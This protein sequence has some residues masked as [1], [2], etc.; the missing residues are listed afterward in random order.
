MNIDV[1]KTTGNVMELQFIEGGSG[2]T[3]NSGMQY[4][5]GGALTY[6]STDDVDTAHYNISIAGPNTLGKDLAVTVGVDQTKILD[7]YANDSIQYEIMPDSLYK[8]I[9]TTAT[10]KAG[11]RVTPMEIAFYPSK[12]DPTKSYILPVVI[13]DAQGQTISSNFA[14]IYFHVIGNPIAGNY[15]WD[16]YRW[17]QDNVDP[18]PTFYPAGSPSGWVDDNMTFIP[19]SPTVVKCYTGY[20]YQIDYNIS[21]T[22]NN[23]VL[24]NFAVKFDNSQYQ[25]YFVANGVTL[26]QGPSIVY[27]APDHSEFEV[28]YTVYNGSQYRYIVDY[29]HKN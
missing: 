6:P 16:Y 25:T 20:Y 26:V 18:V 11:N 22:N 1:T 19:L 10:I 7:N 17:N 13:K 24:S 9:S 27:M 5:G 29:F 28:H 12:I 3:I 21:F 15:L 23:G 2:S 8:F 14:T 4:F